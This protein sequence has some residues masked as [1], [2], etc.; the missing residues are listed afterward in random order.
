MFCGE[1]FGV[2]LQLDIQ[3]GSARS[4][5]HCILCS[6]ITCLSKSAINYFIT[7]KDILA[8][9]PVRSE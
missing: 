4:S 8:V 2:D 1:L 9:K 5:E 6:L 3:M 7:N